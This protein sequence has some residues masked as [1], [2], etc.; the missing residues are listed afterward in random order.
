MHDHPQLWDTHQADDLT[1]FHLD[2]P[3]DPFLRHSVKPVFSDIV[4]ILGWSYLR[5]RLPHH[6]FRRVH[7]RSPIHPCKVILKSS[8]QT[9]W[10]SC[11]T[12]A[13]FPF[14]AME[15]IVF[16]QG[17]YRLHYSV[18]R[19]LFTLLVI[20]SMIFVKMSLQMSSTFEFWPSYYPW[21]F[22][23]LRSQ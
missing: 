19:C 14:S 10:P 15:V 8:R 20:V 16:S 11:H 21:L 9:G 23:R 13:Y 12:R 22:S 7:V 18:K 4:M 2:S 17:G 6:H 1:S 3:M 5:H